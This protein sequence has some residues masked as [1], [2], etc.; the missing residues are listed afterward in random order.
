[1]KL[2]FIPILAAAAVAMAGCSSVKTHVDH[3]P[4]HAKTFSFINTGSRPAPAGADN[5]KQA[6]EMV[7]AA[8]A[9]DLAARGVKQ[10]PA[11]GEVIVAYLIIVG[12]NVTT[13][14]L[15]QYFGYGDDA[16]A[17][18]NQVHNEQAVNGDTR[19]YFEAGSLVIDFVDPATSKL[20]YRETVKSDVRRDLPPDE[21]A[22]RMDRLV[23]KALKDVRIEQ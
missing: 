11:G 1:M 5:Q 13:T 8:I 12:N 3:G 14:S 19:F 18:V 7:Q 10:V 23:A 17:L 16:S 6:H 21:R 22:A 4:V 15:N 20:I 9:K 2:L